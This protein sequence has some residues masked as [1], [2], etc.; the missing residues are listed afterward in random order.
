MAASQVYLGSENTK[1]D[2]HGGHINEAARFQTAGTRKPFLRRPVTN[3]LHK[4]K[5]AGIQ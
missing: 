4:E 2:R 5:S 1:L 3:R